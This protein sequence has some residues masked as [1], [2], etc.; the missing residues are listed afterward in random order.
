MV[1]T[2]SYILSSLKG[3]ITGYLVT[4]LFPQEMYGVYK[5]AL[6][7]IGIIGFLAIP[8]I[9]STLGACIAKEKKNAPVRSA[10]QWYTSWCLLGSII[11]IGSVFIIPSARLNDLWSLLVASA[12]FFIPNNA[13]VHIFSAAVRGTTRFDRAFFATTISNISQVICVLLMLWIRPSAFLLL[14]CTIG[15]PGFVY[16]GRMLWWLRE[17]PSKKS[18]RPWILPSINISLATIPITISWYIDGLLVA[19]Y[20]G[21][22]Q[23]AILSVALLIPEQIKSW[24]KE[25]LPILFSAQA[26]GRDTWERRKKLKKIVLLSTLLTGIGIA[27]YCMITPYIIGVLFPKYNPREVIFLTNIAAITLI[28]MPA[29]LFTQYFEARGMT[30]ELQWCNWLASFTYVISLCILVPWLGPLGAILSR[31]VLRISFGFAGYSI[32]SFSP[33]Q[34]QKSLQEPML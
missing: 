11:T 28:S 4:R 7:I 15:I 1:V 10:M 32:L 29:A 18:F 21:L 23:L 6:S 24:A 3:I 12:I 20:F 5:F 19:A 2:S 17:F 26:Q 27:M 16:L 22:K 25:M 34:K 9:T 8:G 33:V 30:K 13:G 31:G 14:V